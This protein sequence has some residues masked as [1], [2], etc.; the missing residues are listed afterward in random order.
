[1]LRS[2]YIC[3]LAACLLVSFSRASERQQIE[4]LLNQVSLEKTNDKKLDLL[5]DAARKYNKDIQYLPQ[6]EEILNQAII[7]A[8]QDSNLNGLSRIYNSYGV[9]YRNIAQYDKALE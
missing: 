9:L 3:F 1:M 8:S 6:C 7:I 5:L 4:L 2:V